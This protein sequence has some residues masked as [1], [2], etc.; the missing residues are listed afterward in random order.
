MRARGSAQAQIFVACLGAS[1]Y[2][3]AE[4]TWTQALADWIGSHI[5]CLEFLGAV[6]N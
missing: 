5:R 6:P 1:H 4:A 3:Y 2:T